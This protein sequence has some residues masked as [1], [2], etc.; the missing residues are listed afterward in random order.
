MRAK[1]SFDI[2]TR[3]SSRS[4]S[5]VVSESTRDGVELDVCCA[6][7][8]RGAAAMNSAMAATKLRP[9]HARRIA[10]PPRTNGAGPGRREPSC[11][12]NV[13]LENELNMSLFGARA[14]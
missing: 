12:G 11:Y 4:I 6:W 5:A 13:Q 7:A 1:S 9:K 10:Q 8:A 2:A 14:I 3:C